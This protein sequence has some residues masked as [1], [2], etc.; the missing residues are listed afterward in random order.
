LTLPRLILAICACATSLLSVPAIAL[1]PALSIEQYKYTRWG[2]DEGVPRVIISLAQGSDGYLW[3]G[4][5]T[6]LYRFDGFSF[7]FIPAPHSRPTPPGVTAV[8]VAKSG[9]VWVGYGAGGVA[10]FRGGVLRDV[11]GLSDDYIGGLAE[12]PTGAIWALSGRFQKQ[13]SRFAD[14]RWTAIGSDWGLP[15][16]QIWRMFAAHDGTLWVAAD[17]S[18]LV[19]KKGSRRFEQTISV[20]PGPK[21][22]AEDSRGQIWLSAKEGSWAIADRQHVM[23][24][25]PRFLYP[26]PIS[27]TSERTF[28]DKH[29][30]LWGNTNFGVFRVR[31]PAAQGAPSLALAAYGVSQFSQKV[32]MGADRTQ[33]IIGDREGSIWI[34]TGTALARMRATDVVVEPALTN[35]AKWGDPLLG[36]SEGTV[37]V[38]EANGV[39][40][41]PKGGKPE[42]FLRTTEPQAL[43]EGPDKTIWMVLQ[44]RVVGMR[45]G[46]SIILPGPGKTDQGISDCAVDQ[47]G[48]LWLAGLTNGLYRFEDRSWKKF[49]IPSPKS[50]HPPASI[51]RT[52][53]QKLL[54][55]FS[56]PGIASISDTGNPVFL[57]KSD[58]VLGPV[59]TF[60]EGKEGIVLGGIFGLAQLKN[61][62]IR[63]V[64]ATL[65]PAAFMTSG[66]VQTPTGETW[67]RT[68]AGIVRL[69]TEALNRA[70][71]GSLDKVQMKVLDFRDGLPGGP[72]TFSVRDSVR[73]GDGRLW[74]GSAGGVVWVDP[75]RVS[76][77]DLAPP[78]AISAL[79]A[80]GNIFRD[81]ENLTLAPGTSNIT[82]SFSALSLMIPERVQVRYR[83]VGEDNG[84][85]NPAMRRQAFY[86]NLGPG[87]YAFRVIA[88]NNDGVW[89]RAG[90]TLEFVIAPTFFQS[91]W[92]LALCILGVVFLLWA[93]YSLR[94]RQVTNRVR[95]R[96]EE[97][98]AERE[99]IAR[100]LHDTLLQGFQGLILRFQSVANQIPEGQR[101]R[102]L[103]DQA[104]DSADDVLND[105]RASVSQ[106][107]TT[108]QDDLAHML[109][110]T[111]ARMR[112]DY[113]V[114]F[115]MTVEGV[116]RALHPVVREELCRIGDEALINAF[117]HAAASTIEVVISYHHAALLM[118]IRD[119]GIGIDQEVVSGGGRQGHFGLVGM[120]ERA[121]QIDAE[122][123]ISSRAE[124]GTEILVRVRARVAYCPDRADRW[125][126]QLRRLFSRKG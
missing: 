72:S 69:S 53:D 101:A 18:V 26:T 114:A 58:K 93:I 25:A 17:R 73:G 86:T 12:T 47:N 54:S 89:N 94:L 41:V 104:L 105:G 102:G 82:I 67:L 21:S 87:H 100:D 22:L 57:S 4:S 33:T 40:R 75:A 110:E 97:R 107:R 44:D 8:L 74:F 92:F 66:I 124:S 119:D 113:P 23:I 35:A 62:Q 79:R 122:I 95:S 116:P 112:A 56:T 2:I 38:G 14:G 70:F 125:R 43:C 13:L 109:T 121:R 42:L 20:M 28:F 103:I 60:Y 84:W 126:F 78:V 7:E 32:G 76:H 77:N 61:N 49:L 80:G 51:L 83:L 59:R 10:V 29:D 108:G 65:I 123:K 5:A 45:G 111:A 1:D 120:R 6:G 30:N 117:R 68:V 91:R 106:L 118:G 36:A 81:P 48:R 27:Q 98:I 88:A 39:Y 37:Y 19:L 34:G 52:R 63:S 71:S 99:R 31:T 50:D 85:I 11:P 24:P 16:G 96:L 46:K 64:P 115:K 55:I 90:A 15:E 3:I 9:D